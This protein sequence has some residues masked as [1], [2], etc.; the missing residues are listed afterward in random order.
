MIVALAAMSS[1]SSIFQTEWFAFFNVFFLGI[2]EQSRKSWVS[3]VLAN[4]LMIAQMT[5]NVI[6][7][8]SKVFN[9]AALRC[10]CLLRAR[11]QTTKNLLL[12]K[13]LQ[14]LTKQSESHE[15]LH[16]KLSWNK[17]HMTMQMQDCAHNTSDFLCNCFFARRCSHECENKKNK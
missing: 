11:G 4:S 6:F 13:T 7:V 8:A 15:S 2:S 5:R 12:L 3:R 16:D 17:C 10:F 1:L 14:W 9:C